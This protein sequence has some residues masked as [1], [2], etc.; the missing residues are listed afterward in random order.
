VALSVVDIDG[1]ISLCS[2]PAGGR[3]PALF[4]SLTEAGTPTHLETS[5]CPS[6][7]LAKEDH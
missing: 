3:L 4:A 5:L 2:P 7:A 6:E 1:H